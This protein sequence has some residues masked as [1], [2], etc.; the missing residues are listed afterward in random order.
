M[1]I[2]SF[3]AAL[4]FLGLSRAPV[5]IAHRA[6]FEQVN[7]G[8]LKIYVEAIKSTVCEATDEPEE[9]KNDK[10]E[11]ESYLL[12]FS[13]P[14]Y[15]MEECTIKS[16]SWAEYD[17][18]ITICVLQ[19]FD[20]K[21][22]KF[23]CCDESAMF[24]EYARISSRE[25]YFKESELKNLITQDGSFVSF[26]NQSKT[27]LTGSKALPKALALLAREMAENHASFRDGNKVNASAFKRHIINLAEKYID[28]E[29]D[30]ASYLKSINS[31][32]TNTLDELDIRVIKEEK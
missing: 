19:V 21:G 13:E 14:T 7:A 9:L 20:S 1:N 6:I 30:S 11:V 17:K 22:K 27:Q 15:L 25:F 8:N 12:G 31:I 23:Y 4:E 32:L 10:G 2:L 5:Q 24:F 29:K 28:N 26:S 3:E 16:V 18:E